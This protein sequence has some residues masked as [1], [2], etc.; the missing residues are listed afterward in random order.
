MLARLRILF[1]EPLFVRTRHGMVPTPRTMALAPALENLLADAEQLVEPAAFDPRTADMDVRVSANDYMQSTVLV[2]FMRTFRREA[3]LARL[4]IRNPEIAN[5]DRMLAHGELDLAITIPEF[6]DPGLQTR[7]LYRE[8]YVCAVRESHPI[9]SSRVSMK[10]FL[11][12]DHVLMS[13][14]DGRFRGPA[15]DAL[16]R[17]GA[18]RRVAMSVPNFLVLLELLQTDDL[19]AFIPERLLAGRLHSL[20][21]FRPP[22]E[23]DG[24]DVI[25]AWHSRSHH[26]P[27]HTWFRDTLAQVSASAG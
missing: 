17:L 25:M 7:L 1:D 6:A 19:I 24:F 23:V 8:E 20:R 14:S 13:P 15:D 16:A 11:S 9:R 22:V 27:A 18:R 26:D 2:P 3:P 4:A 12:Y 21:L 10:R 5:L